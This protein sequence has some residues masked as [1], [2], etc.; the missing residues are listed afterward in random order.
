[1]SYLTNPYRYAPTSQYVVSEGSWTNT[2][3]YTTVKDSPSGGSSYNRTIAQTLPIEYEI[4]IND[5]GVRWYVAFSTISEIDTAWTNYGTI[6][7][8]AIPYGLYFIGNADPTFVSLVLDFDTP[9][10]FS[11]AYTTSSR[12]KMKL[13]ASQFTVTYSVLG[14]WTDTQTLYDDTATPSGQYTLMVNQNTTL[15]SYSSTITPQ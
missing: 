9:S 13:T 12:F 5:L 10:V 7:E 11:D 8:R 2:D 3:Q 4:A 6:D 15:G 1:M 14:N